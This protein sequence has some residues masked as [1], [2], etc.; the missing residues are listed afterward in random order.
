MQNRDTVY[1][2]LFADGIKKHSS[3]DFKYFFI[4]E[5][6]KY[7]FSI[8]SDCRLQESDRIILESS[9]R[10]RASLPRTLKLASSIDLINPRVAIGNS[11]TGVLKPLILFEDKGIDKV[12]DYSK[13]IIM[14]KEDYYSIFDF[15]ELNVVDKFDLYNIYFMIDSFRDYEHIYE[16]IFFLM[17]FSKA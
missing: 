3:D 11:L 8:F 16:Y 12:I 1:P 17:R 5:E 6:R 7:D 14:T 13:N 4:F 2:L 15:K 10:E 9:D